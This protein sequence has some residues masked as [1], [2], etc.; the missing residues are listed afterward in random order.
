MA[1]DR[2]KK[3]IKHLSVILRICIGLG[4]LGILGFSQ[5][6]SEFGKALSELN[7]WILLAGTC[8]FLFANFII[9]FR[10][11]VLLRTQRIVIGLLAGVKIHFLGLFYNNILISAVGGDLLRAWYVT[12]HTDRKVEAAFSVL[13]DRIIGLCT[14]FMMAVLFYLF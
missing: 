7:L 11:F 1:E 5:D 10:W 3:K 13:V 9:A 12:S 14:L 6:W 8:I 2:P 4:A